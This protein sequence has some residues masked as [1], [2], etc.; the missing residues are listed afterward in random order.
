MNGDR[1][2]PKL[3]EDNGK[4]EF[5]SVSHKDEYKKLKSKRKYQ[6]CTD[7]R[8]RPIIMPVSADCYLQCIMMALD[9]EI[10]FFLI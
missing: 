7:N 2:E 8:N 3:H 4:K 5:F 6:G 1:N 10:I 9:T